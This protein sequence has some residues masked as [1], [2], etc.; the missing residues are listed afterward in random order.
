MEELVTSWGAKAGDTEVYLVFDIMLLGVGRR[1][2]MPGLGS[3][4]PLSRME[5][6]R[7]AAGGRPLKMRYSREDF[8]VYE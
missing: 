2:G 1:Q 8:S 5:P 6:H 7:E 4:P 3:W